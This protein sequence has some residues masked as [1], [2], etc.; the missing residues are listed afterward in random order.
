MPKLFSFD[1]GHASIGWAVFDTASA[2]SPQLEGCGAVIFPADDCLASQRRDFRRQRRHIRST[3]KRIARL[4]ELLKTL[5]VLLISPVA[6]GPGSWLQ[7]DFRMGN[8]FL[9]LNSGTFCGGTPI[10]VATTETGNGAE[11]TQ[12]TLLIRRKNKT[13]AS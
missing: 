8:C 9:G 5:G 13:H 7:G 12:K 3:R 10:T 2:K 1:I 11:A 4:K 6:R